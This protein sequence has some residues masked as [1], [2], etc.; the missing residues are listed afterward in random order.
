MYHD[1]T[2]TKKAL[3]NLQRI[4][5]Q[6][7]EYR[8]IGKP[9]LRVIV[10][11]NKKSLVV[12]ACV[13]GRRTCKTFGPYP[14][15]DLR[16]FERLG[17]EWYRQQLSHDG[18]DYSNV[19]YDQ[20]FFE[21]HLP[22]IQQRNTDWRKVEQMY[23]RYV[24]PHIGHLSFQGIRTHQF[25][26]VLNAMHEQ[27]LSPATKNRVRSLM[28][29]SCVLGVK[30]G[31]LERNPCSA[32]EQY[33]EDNVVERVLTP[34][35][36]TAFVRAALLESNSLHGLALLLDLFIGGR[37][38][39]VISLTKNEVAPD[40][41]TVVFTKT[42]A[43]R[44]QVIPLSD[45][46]KWVL[47]QALELSDPGSPFVFSSTRSRT[48]HIGYPV[49]VFRR[50]CERAC[51]AV[52]SGNH[53]LNPSFPREPLTIHCLRKSFGSAV[54]AHTG[55]IHCSSKLLGHSSVEVTSS[56]YAFYQQAR[57]QDAVQGAAEVM[58]QDVP[59]FPRI[60]SGS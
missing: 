10:Y 37:I 9:H 49:S 26:K 38:H 15:I 58:T 31:V 50:I 28:H 34:P 48:G 55:D 43:K 1:T 2:L 19:T 3:D 46:A 6:N 17:D 29:R 23:R 8:V 53:A 13:G 54:L 42:K 57:L 22:Y 51:I 12:R 33:I 59:N 14:L 4:N 56:R 47:Q 41:S 52:T 30:F 45:Q 7:T 39:N 16:T 5:G 27:G 36:A 21:L 25:M 60:G 40:L 44:K 24:Q 32:I 20:F 35:E 11:R 18:T